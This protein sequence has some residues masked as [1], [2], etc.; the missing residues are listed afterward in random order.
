MSPFSINTVP[1]KD[2]LNAFEL[3]ANTSTPC[4]TKPNKFSRSARD[5]L[6]FENNIRSPFFTPFQSV[7]DI[8]K[9]PRSPYHRIAFE[10]DYQFNFIFH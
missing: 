9:S 7:Y 8:L 3:F 5:E 2:E 6:I 10:P 1:G 4:K